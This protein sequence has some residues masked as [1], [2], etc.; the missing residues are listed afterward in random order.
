VLLSFAASLTD[1]AIPVFFVR[2][3]EHTSTTDGGNQFI[4]RFELLVYDDNW[5]SSPTATAG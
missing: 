3:R 4:A 5:V 1:A 2:S